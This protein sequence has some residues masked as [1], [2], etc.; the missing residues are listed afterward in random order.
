M[1]DPKTIDFAV[2]DLKPGHKYVIFVDPTAVD[3]DTL[4]DVRLDADAVF[5]PVAVP[6]GKTVSDCVKLSPRGGT[7]EEFIEQF[8]E[9]E[10]NGVPD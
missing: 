3:L 7:A 10:P 6:P 2:L 9:G 8:T 1:N 4:M 5:I